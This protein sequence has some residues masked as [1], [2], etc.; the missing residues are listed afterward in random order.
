MSDGNGSVRISAGMKWVIGIAF[1]VLFGLGAPTFSYWVGRIDKADNEITAN[2]D[3]L[4]KHELEPWHHGAGMRM[5]QAEKHNSEDLAEV[6]EDVKNLSED[7]EDFFGEQREFN[8]EMRE[9][10]VEQR[11]VNIRVLDALER[12]DK[13][14]APD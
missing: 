11:A 14:E 4:G 5:E 13:P 1:L 10:D 8:F 6:K 9:R 12:L 7:V 3:S 2:A